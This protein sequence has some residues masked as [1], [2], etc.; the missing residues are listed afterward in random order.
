MLKKTLPHVSTIQTQE[1]NAYRKNRFQKKQ[2]TFKNVFLAKQTPIK[3]TL[4]NL[5]VIIRNEFDPI[6]L[7]HNIFPLTT[8]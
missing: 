7:I 3:F 1:I 6:E 8:G 5:I 2:I 4:K